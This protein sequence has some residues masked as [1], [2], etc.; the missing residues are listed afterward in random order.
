MICGE[1]GTIGQRSSTRL[2]RPTL[3]KKYPPVYTHPGKTMKEQCGSLPK[4]Q[5][6]REACTHRYRRPK[7]PE[8]RHRQH[9]HDGGASCRLHPH[10]PPPRLSPS[11]EIF[12]APVRVPEPVCT[13]YRGLPPWWMSMLVDMRASW[14]GGYTN[15]LVRSAYPRRGRQHG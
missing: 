10:R 1:Y 9:G 3:P 4:Y 6:Q 14:C 15:F 13:P 2:S 8:M 7:Q 11:Y 12:H 5:P